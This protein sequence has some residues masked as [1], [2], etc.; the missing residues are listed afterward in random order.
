[1]SQT[2]EGG[3]GGRG[4]GAGGAEDGESDVGDAAGRFEPVATSAAGRVSIVESV[5]DGAAAD[6]GGFVRGR[7]G[8]LLLPPAA[9]LRK[10]LWNVSRSRRTF[11]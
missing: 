3:R 7:N 1:M 6:A 8:K 11:V 2:G 5:M 9:V 4:R 10:G